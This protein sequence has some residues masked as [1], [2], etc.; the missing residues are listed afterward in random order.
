MKH[1]LFLKELQEKLKSLDVMEQQEK[2]IRN[3]NY[4]LEAELQAKFD[5]LFGGLNDDVE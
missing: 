3:E 5:E 1:E 2:N 4:D